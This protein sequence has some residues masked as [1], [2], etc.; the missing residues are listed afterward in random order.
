VGCDRPVA[1][2]I[3]GCRIGGK[4]GQSTRDGSGLGTLPVVG[5]VSLRFSEYRVTVSSFVNLIFLRIRI[6]VSANN[7]NQFNISISVI[8]YLHLSIR[9]P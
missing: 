1:D 5:V 6:G 8:Q 7:H 4:G 9:L 2:Q 3:V